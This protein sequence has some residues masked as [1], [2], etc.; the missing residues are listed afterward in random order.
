MSKKTLG[1]IFLIIILPVVVYLLVPSDA[2]RIK[3]L[4]KEGAKAVEREDIDAVMSK[5]SFNYRDEYG[6]TY[7]YVKESM[8][9]VFQRMSDIKIEYENLIVNVKGKSA[10]A[11][12]DVR[13]IASIGDNTGYIMGDLSK[14][15]HLTFTLEKE[16]T[17]W[18]IVKTEGLPF[19]L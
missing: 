15:V 18:L 5:V 1:L 7:L 16:R 17:K 12:I 14:P 2:S 9:S 10:T 4:F 8:K 13:V 11:E 3:K 19:D 6:F